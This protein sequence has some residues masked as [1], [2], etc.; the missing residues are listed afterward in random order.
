MTPADAPRLKPLDMRQ[1]LREFGL[2]PN[3]SLGQNWL[4]D[5]SALS[6]IPVAAE[7]SP[8]DVVLEIGPG[9]GAFE[10]VHPSRWPGVVGS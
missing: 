7:L 5:E 4:V 6:R 3:K 10:N 9:L 2:R 8:Q 1:L